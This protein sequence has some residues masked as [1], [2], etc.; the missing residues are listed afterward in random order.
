MF[1]WLAEEDS[2]PAINGEEQIKKRQAKTV[3]FFIM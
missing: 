3:L 1:F 2:A